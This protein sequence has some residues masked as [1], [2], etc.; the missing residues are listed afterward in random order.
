M[1]HQVVMYSV[2]YNRPEFIQVQMDSFRHFFKDPFE[3]IIV[4]NASAADMERRVN[5]ESSKLSL[6]T[7]RTIV[8][9]NALDGHKHQRCLNSVLQTHVYDEKRPVLMMDGDFFLIAP[10]SIN[11]FMENFQICGAKQ[12]RGKYKYLIANFLMLKPFMLPNVNTL[13]LDGVCILDD[14]RAGTCWADRHPN[15]TPLDSGGELYFYF[16]NN[17]NVQ[18]KGIFHS[19]NIRKEN[20]NLHILPEEIRS[21][22]DDFN[23]EIYGNEF[24]HY[25]R[26]S[27]WDHCTPQHHIDKANLM[28]K[29]IY[30]AIDGSIKIVA[31]NYQTDSEL[32]GWPI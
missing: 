6:K 32:F 25:C 24:L 28:R 9:P 29:F 7:I 14:Q 20:N 31:H 3:L 2:V 21:Q 22:Y 10:F 8:D 15:S 4:N 16:K 30:G 5:E 17:P 18:V 1:N 13:K 27:N 12:K 19:G 23:F 26:S 11:D